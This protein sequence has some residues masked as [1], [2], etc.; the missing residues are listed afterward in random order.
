MLIG[1]VRAI[2]EAPA[3]SQQD[4]YAPAIHEVVVA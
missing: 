2:A 4:I 1:F 3:R